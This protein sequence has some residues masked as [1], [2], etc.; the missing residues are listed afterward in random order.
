MWR[1]NTAE[2]VYQ[3]NLKMK[4]EEKIST[5]YRQTLSDFIK[6]YRAFSKKFKI[7]AKNI[8][9]STKNQVDSLVDLAHDL[10]PK[11][12]SADD[13]EDADDTAVSV[14]DDSDDDATVRVKSRKSTFLQN[15]VFTSGPFDLP[16]VFSIYF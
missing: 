11:I 15:L 10:A 6:H 16:A 3:R 13:A 4:L 14:D 1:E 7:T 2:K 5:K 8:L 9:F 12:G